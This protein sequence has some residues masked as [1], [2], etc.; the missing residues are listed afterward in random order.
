MTQQKIKGAPK[1]FKSAADKAK[2]LALC[3]DW[4]TVVT[5]NSK[6][7]LGTK[8]SAKV[9]AARA[10]TLSP[11]QVG[12][13]VTH[14]DQYLSKATPGGSAAKH[15]TKVY[16]GDTLIGIGQLHKSNM[17]PVFRQEDAVDIARMRR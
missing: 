13:R 3:A 5:T 11:Q 16:S 12:N 17:V 1:K 7:L 2:F 8:I 4:E 6:P 9:D 14:N 15:A 10:V